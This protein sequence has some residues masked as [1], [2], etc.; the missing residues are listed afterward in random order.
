MRRNGSADGTGRWRTWRTRVRGRPALTLAGAA[1][2]DGLTHVWSPGDRL[3]DP[4]AAA[5]VYT[6]H[7]DGTETLTYTATNGHGL[8]ASD[9]AE[10]TTVNAAPEVGEVDIAA[11]ATTVTLSAAVTDPGR[12]DTH[13]AEVDW[14]DG[15][16]EA[17][18]VTQG[19]GTATLA[20]THTYAEPG[21][22]AVAV[23]VTDDDGG[24]GTWAGEAAVGCTVLG[25]EDDDRLL[26]TR[27][28]DVIC[29][30]GGDDV[31]V[32]GRG[33]D[34]VVGGGGDDLLLGQQGDDALSGG[35]GDD[36]LHGHRGRDVLVGGPGTDRAYGGPGRD[37]CAA[38]D[39][40]SCRRTD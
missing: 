7:D 20:G 2:G 37:R 16:V 36:R 14:G 15:T 32:A 30:L 31:V 23:R 24:A 17:L 25:T 9:T 28:D 4:T 34:V 22:Y 18:T 19:P 39:S 33:D 13:R 29:G 35:E 10:V 12:G 21:G 8:G 11:D 5:P 26:G 6:G 40:R 3:D 27:G 38:E 1:E